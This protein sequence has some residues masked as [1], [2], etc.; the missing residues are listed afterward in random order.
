L[1]F[2][3][4]HWPLASDHKLC[5]T[6][7]SLSAIA[8]VLADELYGGRSLGEGGWFCLI[9]KSISLKSTPLYLFGYNELLPCKSFKRKNYYQLK[10]INFYMSYFYRRGK[11]FNFLRI[12]PSLRGTLDFIYLNTQKGITLNYGKRTHGGY[13]LYS[14]QGNQGIRKF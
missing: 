8:L 10:K 6:S 7:G 3:T 1:F 13:N 11:L 14:I 5:L 4:N 9:F 12:V 2:A